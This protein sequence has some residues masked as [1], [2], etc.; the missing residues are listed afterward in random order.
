LGKHRSP[1]TRRWSRCTLRFFL[2]FFTFIFTRCT[3]RTGNQRLPPPSSSTSGSRVSYST[4]STVSIHS[5]RLRFQFCLVCPFIVSFSL[6][7]S[8][9]ICLLARLCQALR[10][11]QSNAIIFTFF[12]CSVPF[13]FTYLSSFSL[14]SSLFV[15]PARKDVFAADTFSLSPLLARCLV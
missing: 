3:V 2:T 1:L 10:V 15:K 12:V 11:T 6:F 7:P 5:I 13:W 14:F 4:T 9:F 8:L